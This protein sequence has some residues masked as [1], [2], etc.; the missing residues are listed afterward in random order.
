[1]TRVHASIAAALDLS[2][3]SNHGR[4][5]ARA[6]AATLYIAARTAPMCV[7]Q[8]VGNCMQR[9]RWQCAIENHRENCI[10]PA[11]SG[12]NRI[13]S[14]RKQI[15][16]REPRPYSCMCRLRGKR[17]RHRCKRTQFRAPRENVQAADDI[18]EK[19]LFE[20][21]KVQWQYCIG[22]MDKFV[23]MWNFL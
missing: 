16:L 18:A 11:C 8:R 7:R 21:F 12:D 13:V 3:G 9:R 14:N 5:N 6:I 20:F 4:T 17:D 23:I 2:A 1:M 22:T 15:A 10:R 19:S